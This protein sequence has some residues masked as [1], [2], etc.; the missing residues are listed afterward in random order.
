MPPAA[1]PSTPHATGNTTNQPSHPSMAFGIN[2][3]PARTDNAI[4]RQSSSKN[5]ND[6]AVLN[7]Q[8]KDRANSKGS[9]KGMAN[10]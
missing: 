3:A 2:S 7:I 10:A 5:T 9:G 6:K 1:R 4:R 8:G